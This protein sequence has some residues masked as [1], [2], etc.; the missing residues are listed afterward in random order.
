MLTK[1]DTDSKV[2]YLVCSLI[3]QGRNKPRITKWSWITESHKLGWSS[4]EEGTIQAQAGGSQPDQTT[5]QLIKGVR[6]RKTRIEKVAQ[7]FDLSTQAAETGKSLWVWRKPSLQSE[8]QGYAETLSPKKQ[9]KRKQNKTS[10]TQHKGSDWFPA[11]PEKLPREDGWSS[12]K[13]DDVLY[14]EIL[15]TLAQTRTLMLIESCLLAVCTCKSNCLGGWYR[16]AF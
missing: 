3:P 7:T 11:L 10:P 14:N 15:W 6:L 12:P 16:I 2:S 1:L 8:F 13:N 9:N 5:G 4:K